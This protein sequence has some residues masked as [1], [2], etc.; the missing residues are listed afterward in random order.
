M[1]Q[2]FHGQYPVTLHKTYA[3]AEATRNKL[4]EET[5]MMPEDL[6][7]RSMMICDDNIEDAEVVN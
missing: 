1:Y 7:I 3:A 4:I 6:T 2:V 5:N